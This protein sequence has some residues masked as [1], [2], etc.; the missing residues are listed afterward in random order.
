MPTNAPSLRTLILVAGAVVLVGPLLVAFVVSLVA[1]PTLALAAGLAT[2]LLLCLLT[3]GGGWRLTRQIEALATNAEHLSKQHAEARAAL[4][5]RAHRLEAVQDV[6]NEIVRELDL[7]TLLETIIARA[8]Q[9]V[10]AASGTI[11]L[12]DAE[13]EELV[14]RAF[15]R[16]DPWI[17]TQR[18]KLGQATGGL[19]A[20]RREAVIVNDYRSWP[21]ANP[22]VVRRTPITAVLA[23]PILFQDELIGT[24]LIHHEDP[25]RQFSPE[26]R[27]T[28]QLFA[29]KAAVAIRNASLY[30]AEA[31]ARE[32]ARAADLAKG[33]LLATMS[34]EIRTPMNG[35]I[36][37]TS[38]LL[39]TAL[40]PLQREYAETIRTSG[41]V[42]LTVIDDIL[43]F[44]KIEAGKLTIEARPFDLPA[45]VDA[46][47]SLLGP[48]AAERSLVL[49]SQVDPSLPRK[50]VGD[51]VRIRQIVLNLVSNAV[52]F[53]EHGSVEL[54]VTRDEGGEEGGGAPHSQL[55]THNS[56]LVTFAVH[57]TGIGI[58]AEKLSQMFE[59]FTQADNSTIRHYGGTGLGLAISKRLV[60]LMGGEIG[61]ESEVG[62]G[63]IFWVTLP[64][65][66]EG[67]RPQP[68][69]PLGEGWGEG[70]SPLPAHGAV[71]TSAQPMLAPR[72]GS[73]QPMLA[74]RSGQGSQGR[75]DEA[76]SGGFSGGD[77]GTRILVVEDDPIG[78]R[79]AVQLVERLGYPVDAV[80]GGQAAIDAVSATAY[81]LVLMDC[82][83]PGVDGYM[84]TA[85]IRRREA[86]LGDRAQRVPIVALTASR[87]DGD[88]DR[89]LEAGMDEYLS[90]PIDGQ[91][92]A[93]L[94]SR[95]APAGNAV[96]P[97][98][99]A[100][101]SAL[102]A[103]QMHELPPILDPAGLLGSAA[104][105][106]RP[107]REIVE[108]FLEEAPRRL[109]TLTVASARGDRDQVARLAHSLAGSANSLG[110]ARLAAA[111]VRLETLARDPPR[112]SDGDSVHDRAA[113]TR[114]LS[115]GLLAEAI[116]TVRQE[117][118]QVQAALAGRT[119]EGAGGAHRAPH[120]PRARLS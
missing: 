23:T 109:S 6:T 96:P 20:Q 15:Y 83:M 37:M 44:S 76:E 32:A 89:C 111:C 9:L 104:E 64:L 93:A 52:K 82:Q 79:V 3:L 58:P 16:V 108:L 103:A 29:A 95:W 22:E 65:A 26:D 62:K 73:A 70:P 78:Q 11:F 86:A 5:D 116:S 98:E 7:T 71:G 19:A 90:K 113:S 56:Q 105:L 112:P 33:E 38:L 66:P 119:T 18:L 43:D 102:P 61:A 55:P 39:E 40:D 13:S 81:T 4:A 45:S 2:A 88:R 84:A 28:V 63:S 57:D 68:P 53:T 97:R 75:V 50:L 30:Q 54:R 80:S 115:G 94:L 27:E 24:L 41:E 46:V 21:H 87:V 74:P 14:V 120:D 100:P 1:S 49:T 101:V 91:Q 92:L 77:E 107:H 67:P 48:R 51:E 110:A 47:V 59:R 99:P 34:H 17:V 85:E 72:S 35:V 8:A 42:L 12:W 10:G 117:L 69:L 25:T 31:A 36:G 106:S 60:E 118:Q 114:P